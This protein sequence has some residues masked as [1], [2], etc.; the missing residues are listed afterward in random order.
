MEDFATKWNHTWTGEGV[1]LDGHSAKTTP[2]QLTWDLEGLTVQEASNTTL[3]PAGKLYIDRQFPP[4]ELY[5]RVDSLEGV[6]VIKDMLLYTNIATLLPKRTYSSA[7]KYRAHTKWIP[8][9]LVLFVCFGFFFY[10]K[11]LPSSVDVT[12]QYLPPKLEK[13]LG[14][15]VF[16]TWIPQEDVRT[17]SVASNVSAKLETWLQHYSKEKNLKTPFPYQVHFVNDTSVVNAFALPGGHI[18]LYQGLLNFVGSQEELLGILSHEAGHIYHQHSMKHLVRSTFL[19]VVFSLV[20]GDVSGIAALLLESS[21]LLLTLSHTREGEREADVFAIQSMLYHNIHPKYL[22]AFFE[23][24]EIPSINS[25]KKE[26]EK[27]EAQKEEVGQNQTENVDSLP[28]SSQKKWNLRNTL[29]LFSTHPAGEERIRRFQ[30]AYPDSN[31]KNLEPTL[32][33]SR[34]L[35]KQLLGPTKAH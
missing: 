29:S 6:Y 30:E 2:V 17:D 3:Y 16:Q 12:V 18:V 32:P 11:V 24:L 31:Q 35:W 21:E 19:G 23:R 5:I 10:Y 8:I 28:N 15:Q 34:S 7:N 26:S 4:N 20:L 13:Q 1:F 9:A 33:I 22:T 27:Q 14:E 25:E